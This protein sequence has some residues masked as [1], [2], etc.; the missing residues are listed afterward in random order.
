ML[1]VIFIAYILVVIN[2]SLLPTAFAS[3]G[4]YADK[5]SH[6]AAYCVM[7]IIAYFAGNSV[8]TRI[9]LFLIILCIGFVLELFQIFIPGRHASLF[10]MLANI[11]GSILG[12]FLA[13]LVSLSQRKVEVKLSC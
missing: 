9:Y 5:L 13:W 7:G 8:K 1:Q 2:L 12:Y 6:L 11:L 3:S 10:D 4:A